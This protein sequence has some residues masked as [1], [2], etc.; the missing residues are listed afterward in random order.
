MTLK[1][2][3]L[4]CTRERAWPGKELPIQQS[5]GSRRHVNV[6]FVRAASPLAGGEEALGE[7]GR[8]RSQ[9]HAAAEEEHGRR[10]SSV[11]LRDARPH[12]P[13]QGKGEGGLGGGG[14]MPTG[15]VAAVRVNFICHERL[16]LTRTAFFA[17]PIFF[18]PAEPSAPRAEHQLRQHP[19]QN[20]LLIQQG[21]RWPAYEQR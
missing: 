5:V 16:L 4:I 3:L 7:G 1:I 21:K 8:L 9:R 6:S 2:N 14:V 10:H 17:R 15:S 20:A 12:F 13:E 11:L 19:S 18:P